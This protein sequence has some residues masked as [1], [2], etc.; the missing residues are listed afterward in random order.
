MAPLS[1]SEHKGKDLNKI[2]EEECSTKNDVKEYGE[3][4]VKITKSRL[5]I[6]LEASGRISFQLGICL[7]YSEGRMEEVTMVL[8]ASGFSPQVFFVFIA[9]FSEKAQSRS[10]T[11]PR[12]WFMA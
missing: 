1:K 6:F 7:F 2:M 11:A 3:I 10:F 8:I 12:V 4:T 5:L 9:L